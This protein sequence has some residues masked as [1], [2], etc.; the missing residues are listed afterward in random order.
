MRGWVDTGSLLALI[1]ELVDAHY[2][3]IEIAALDPA[4]SAELS[5]HIRYLQDLSRTAMGVVARAG[6][7]T[8]RPSTFP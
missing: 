6:D 5:S 2:D 3:T 1:D 8:S 4:G 7:G